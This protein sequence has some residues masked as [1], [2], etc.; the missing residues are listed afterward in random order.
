MRIT[1][2]TCTVVALFFTQTPSAGAEVLE[3]QNDGFMSGQAAGFQA[4]L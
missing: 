2:I 4:G 1:A 3:L